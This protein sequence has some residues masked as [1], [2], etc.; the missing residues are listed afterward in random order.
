M[1][2]APAES[3]QSLPNR[4]PW[5]RLGSV[6]YTCNRLHRIRR[7]FKHFWSN[8]LSRPLGLAIFLP[9][10]LPGPSERIRLPHR[11]RMRYRRLPTTRPSPRDLQG[12]IC[13]RK[14]GVIWTRWRPVPVKNV[15]DPRPPRNRNRGLVGPHT[16][17]PI[18]NY[19]YMPSTL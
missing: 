18:I 11:R 2:A 15:N 14:N 9:C 19:K 6:L 7:R 1:A 17:P 13:P 8:S 10:L 3:C 4:S 12:P 5:G 16:T